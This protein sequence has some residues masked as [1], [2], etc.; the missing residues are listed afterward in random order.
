MAVFWG[1][2]KLKNTKNW[3]YELKWHTTK[4]KEVLKINQLH[5]VEVPSFP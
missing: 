2:K 3:W 5:R 1:L 4:Y